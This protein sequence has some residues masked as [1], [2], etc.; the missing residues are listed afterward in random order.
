MYATR[1]LI[2]A[3]DMTYDSVALRPGDLFLATDVDAGYLIRHGRAREEHREAMVVAPAQVDAFGPEHEAL[4][5]N[6]AEVSEAVFV[7]FDESFD[8]MSV[9]VR[10]RLHHG[11]SSLPAFSQLPNHRMESNDFL[12]RTRRFAHSVTAHRNCDAS[13]TAT[14]FRYFGRFHICFGSAGC[15]S[16]SL[17][18]RKS[19]V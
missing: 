2:A 16:S 17:I 11:N 19:V 5:A 7:R 14:R 10:T 9:S 13:I 12:A 8:P 18:D 3:I 6:R 15:S 4:P 1:R